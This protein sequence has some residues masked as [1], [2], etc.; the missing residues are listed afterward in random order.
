LPVEHYAITSS[1][2][3]GIR[4]IREIGDID[5]ICDQFLWDKLAA[6]CEVFYEFGVTKIRI[7]PNIEALGEKSFYYNFDASDPSVD[8]QIKNCEI[9]DGLPFVDLKYILYFKTKMDRA[10]DKTDAILIKEYL[11]NSLHK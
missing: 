5:I 6:D 2:P 1:G 8:E 4:D 7:A 10:K 3:M 9:I 11:N